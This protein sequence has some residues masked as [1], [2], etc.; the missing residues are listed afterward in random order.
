MVTP[1]KK[2]DDMDVVRLQGM[3]NFALQKFTYLEYSSMDVLVFL[4]QLMIK[5]EFMSEKKATPIR[6][7]FEFL[8]KVA[9]PELAKIRAQGDIQLAMFSERDF[10]FAIK[11]FGLYIRNHNGINQFVP[12][13]ELNT[14]DEVVS[15]ENLNDAKKLEFYISDIHKRT[16]IQTH[17]IQSATNRLLREWREIELSRIFSEQVSLGKTIGQARAYLRE[18]C[19]IKDH[20]FV[21]IREHAISRGWFVSKRRLSKANRRVTLDEDVALYI[22]ELTQ[23]MS[24]SS[25]KFQSMSQATNQALRDMKILTE[26]PVKKMK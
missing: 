1:L 6:S 16:K 9:E 23:T 22:E 19:D 7:S 8:R 2:Y 21:R 18:T 24:K 14:S 17:A 15:I 10:I 25:T 4:C 12:D 11:M 5:V 20:E 26:A 13:D 3:I